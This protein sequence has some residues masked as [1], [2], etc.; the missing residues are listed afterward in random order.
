MTSLVLIAFCVREIYILMPYKLV[1]G[2]YKITGMLHNRGYYQ[3]Q[4]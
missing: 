1:K 4:R 3:Q 2:I